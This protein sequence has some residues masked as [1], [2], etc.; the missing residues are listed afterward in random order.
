[1]KTYRVNFMDINDGRVNNL[2]ANEE[3]NDLPAFV[4]AKTISEVITKVKKLKL[5]Y[6]E[7]SSIALT[8]ENLKT[9]K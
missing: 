5:E 2:K 1:M 8:H 6:V 4:E 9:L 3:W 7:L